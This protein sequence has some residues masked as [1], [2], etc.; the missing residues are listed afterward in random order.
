VFNATNVTVRIEGKRK[1]STEWFEVYTHIFTAAT[2]IGVTFPVTE[3]SGD[4][5]VGALVTADG[6][7]NTLNVSVDMFSQKK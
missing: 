2:T 1:G 3:Y 7:V 6:G 4:T 5:R